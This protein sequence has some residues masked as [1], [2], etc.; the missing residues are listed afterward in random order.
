[1]TRTGLAVALLITV[2]IGLLFGIWPKLDLAV[3]SLFLH[4]GGFRGH[5]SALRNVA[6]VIVGLAAAPFALALL[7]KLVRSRLDLLIPGRAIALVL[8]TLLLVPGILANPLLK[9][10]WGRPRPYAVSNFGAHDQ[11]RAWWDMRGDCR[12][13]CSFIAGEP[14]AA[15]WTIAPAAVAPPQW[16]ALAYG[17]AIVFGCAVSVLRVAGGAHF[18]TDVF[19]AGFFAFVV[20]WIV[21]GL[22]YRW[23]WTPLLGA[24]R[25][26]LGYPK[27]DMPR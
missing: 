13:N 4:R 16:R 20:I 23:D 15:F 27:P 7:L 25:Q 19:F 24:R 22:L 17:A 9:D 6:D 10:H 3:S 21:H 1:M 14:S 2:V 11:F 8:V 26:S 12:N 5:Y 18:F